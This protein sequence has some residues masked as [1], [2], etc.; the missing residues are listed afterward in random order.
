MP[1]RRHIS[2]S[3]VAGSASAPVFPM[4]VDRL[5]A[6]QPRGDGL[7]SRQKRRGGPPR[8]FR[9]G[10]LARGSLHCGSAEGARLQVCQDREQSLTFEGPRLSQAALDFHDQLFQKAC[11][12]P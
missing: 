8:Q 4:S 3:A 2:G 7:K 11:H 5:P 1:E 10:S 12:C 6:E 9:R